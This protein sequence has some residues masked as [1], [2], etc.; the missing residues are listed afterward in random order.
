[1]SA[2]VQYLHASYDSYRYQTPLRPGRP[3]SECTVDSTA[4]FLV[5][6]SGRRSPYAPE[7]THD[8]GVVQVL[9]L[10]RR[11]NLIARARAH[12]QSQTLVGLEFLSQEQQQSY[13]TLDASLTLAS[14]DQRHSIGAF[15]Q[16]LTN[17]TI[18]SNAFVVPFSRFPVTVLRPP[19]TLGVRMVEHF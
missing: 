16:N 19:R 10:E 9:P 12:H 8:L 6:C 7:W 13:W 4:S 3:V 17:Q 5:D 11:A 18:M 15:G 14:A 2:S 1:V